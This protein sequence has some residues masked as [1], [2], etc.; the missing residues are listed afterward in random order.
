MFHELIFHLIM[1]TGHGNVNATIHVPSNAR[2]FLKA[3]SVTTTASLNKSDSTSPII[4]L[5]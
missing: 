2:K 4:C 1:L 3:R 5:F